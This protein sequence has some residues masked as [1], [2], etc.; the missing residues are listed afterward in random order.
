[1]TFWFVWR[2]VFG[3]VAATGVLLLVSDFLRFSLKARV[4]RAPVE[5]APAPV[6][7]E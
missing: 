6:S 1:M 2:L 7:G 4:R 3:T 5:L